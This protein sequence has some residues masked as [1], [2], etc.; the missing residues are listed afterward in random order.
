MDNYMQTYFLSYI[1]W[2]II[3]QISS[4]THFNLHNPPNVLINLKK[5]AGNVIKVAWAWRTQ[6]Y[7]FRNCVGEGSTNHAATLP[8]CQPLSRIAN[9]SEHLPIAR[10]R[11]CEKLYGPTP[12]YSHK[13]LQNWQGFAEQGWGG[14]QAPFLL[15]PVGL[16]YTNTICT[17]RC[18]G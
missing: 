18:T 4:C 6:C 8:L 15:V 3:Y 11:F 2:W 14:Q 10:N 5:V 16:L 1:C 17:V 13:Q 9:V 7:S 12:P